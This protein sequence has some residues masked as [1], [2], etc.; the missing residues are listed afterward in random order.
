MGLRPRIRHLVIGKLEK[1]VG[2]LTQKQHGGAK[3][4]QRGDYFLPYGFNLDK[5]WQE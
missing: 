5:R 4:E 2:L 3:V 1:W